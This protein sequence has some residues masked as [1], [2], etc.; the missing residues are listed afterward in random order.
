[1]IDTKAIRAR[2]DN[3]TP[4]PWTSMGYMGTGLEQ[5]RDME[6]VCH[7]REDVPALCN[8]VDRVRSVARDLLAR[9]G[10]G[11]ISR[12]GVDDIREALRAIGGEG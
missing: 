1:M 12:I 11:A 4:G 8:E 3:A 7:A 5:S 10:D 2:A 6:F 9:I